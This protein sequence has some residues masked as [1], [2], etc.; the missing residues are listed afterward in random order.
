LH[1]TKQYESYTLDGPLPAFRRDPTSVVSVVSGIDEAGKIVKDLLGRAHARVPPVEANLEL[2][3]LHV[4]PPLM[5]LSTFLGE[6]ITIRT[7]TKRIYEDIFIM[8]D[9]TLDERL[10]NSAPIIAIEAP[11]QDQA[12]FSTVRDATLQIQG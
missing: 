6:N 12:S 4:L 9:T 1:I 10:Y 3:N 8:W 2:R 7:P 11:S 5:C